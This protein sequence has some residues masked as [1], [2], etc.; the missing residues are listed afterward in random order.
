MPLDLEQGGLL[1]STDSGQTWHEL[2]TWFLPGDTFYRD[3]HR[4]VLAVRGRR[5]V[6]HRPLGGHAVDSAATRAWMGGSCRRGGGRRQPASTRGMMSHC[7]STMRRSVLSS[8][9]KSVR[10]AGLRP[11]NAAHAAA[12]GRGLGLVR[13]R[14]AFT[15]RLCKRS[16]ISRQ[17]SQILR[18]HD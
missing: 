1:R 17:L 11:H 15:G 9:G 16:V 6:G 10:G 18:G 12:S 3:S 4:L 7:S 2:D 14:S 5:G 13:V 8:P